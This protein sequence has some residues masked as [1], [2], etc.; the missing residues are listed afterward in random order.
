M[1]AAV[2]RRKVD[3]LTLDALFRFAPYPLVKVAQGVGIHPN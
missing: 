1:L 2:R 3:A